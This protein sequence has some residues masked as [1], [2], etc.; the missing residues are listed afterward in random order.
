MFYKNLI[1]IT[2][3]SALSL[4]VNAHRDIDYMPEHGYAN[5]VG[6]EYVTPSIKRKLKPN[7]K[8]KDLAKLNF[9]GEVIVQKL[10]ERTY[11]LQYDFYSVVFH[12]GEKGVLLMDPLAYG[13]GKKVLEGIRKVT[14]LPI[15]TLVYT[16][17]RPDHLEDATVFVGDAKAKGVNL[18]I[19]ASEESAKIIEK[20][21][22]I[23]AP[24]RLVS[25]D[26]GAFQFED[27]TVTAQRLS[28][29]LQ[30]HDNAIWTIVQD[31]VALQTHLLNPDQVPFMNF[32][33]A[34]N[35]NSYKMQ[36]EE[37]QSFDWTFL[38][39]G[40]G[41]IGTKADVK[42]TQKYVKDME[43]A[44][45][46]AYKEYREKGLGNR[47]F[48]NHHAKWHAGREYAD[49]RAVELLRQTYGDV[50]GFEAAVS[51]HINTFLHPGLR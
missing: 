20:N 7:Q 22:K 8:I 30:S 42:Y 45:R 25:L 46:D 32:A 29:T 24:T 19:I 48:N 17:Y 4:N 6:A 23:P 2:F 38:S 12:V 51:S 9:D 50:Y 21:K 27:V 1:A 5:T 49:T 43:Q 40:H 10:T 47:K 15:T 44:V 26:K 35:Y 18:E 39:S 36:L 31:K 34:K 11:W 3:F 28:S 41:G 16:S 37:V 33:G 13:K 14:S